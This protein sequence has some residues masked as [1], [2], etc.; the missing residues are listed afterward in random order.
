M[1][2]VLI[3]IDSL[4]GIRARDMFDYVLKQSRR[5][6]LYITTHYL[7]DFSLKMETKGIMHAAMSQQKQVIPVYGDITSEEQRKLPLSLRHLIPIDSREEGFLK[8]LSMRIKGEDIEYN[9]FIFYD[10]RDE[11][12][13]EQLSQGL[14]R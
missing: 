14:W 8:H 6:L 4:H 2:C 11:I 12:E 5:I 10:G 1:T 7:Q 3:E 9:V 13:V